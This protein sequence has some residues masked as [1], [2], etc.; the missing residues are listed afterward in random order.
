MATF[1]DIMGA[2]SSLSPED[3][4]RLI[5]ALWDTVEID[6]WPAPS[7]EWIEETKRRSAEL[8]AGRMETSKWSEV[9][10]RARRK[11]GLDG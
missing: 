7:E 6:S 9:K 8:D 11:A 4:L 3:R 5:D 2:A 1:D 10:M